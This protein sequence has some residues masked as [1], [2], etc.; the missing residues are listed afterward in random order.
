[1]SWKSGNRFSDKDMR[2]TKESRRRQSGVRLRRSTRVARPVRRA[3]H[4]QDGRCHRRA[5]AACN[6]V[7]IDGAT[8]FDAVDGRVLQGLG[9]RRGARNE[10]DAQAGLQQSDEVAFGCELV[11]LIHIEMMA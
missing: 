6:A 5:L 11:A 1:M 9:T 7:E 10:R 4:L 3:Q 8:Q 2:K